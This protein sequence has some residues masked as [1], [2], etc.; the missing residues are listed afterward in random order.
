MN[1][2]D[3]LAGFLVE[4]EE[5]LRDMEGALLDCDG[6]ATSAEV[7]NR[8]FRCAHTIKGSAGLF[9]LQDIVEFVHVLET[10]L[11]HVR[12]GKVPLHETLISLLLESRDH[13]RALVAA[14]GTP[15]SPDS[16]LSDQSARLI[17]ALHAASAIGEPPPFE[18]EMHPQRVKVL[19]S[20][21]ER[22]I[23]NPT[24][25]AWNLLVRFAPGVLASGMDPL[26]VIGYLGTFCE[27]CK[28]TI[29]DEALPVP[30]AFQPQECYL[31]FK[32]DLRTAADRSRIESA[33]DF[34]RD[35]C[36]LELTEAATDAHSSSVLRE[37]PPAPDQPAPAPP[38]TTLAPSA[39]PARGN[40]Q[41][42]QTRSSS[43]DTHSSVRVDA[44][45]LDAL[46]TRVG[47]L[48]IETAA[49]DMVARR[50][51]NCE[52]QERS[53]RLSALV[54]EVRENALQLRMIKIGGVFERFRRIVRD[55]SRGLGKDI[56]LIVRGQDTELDKT[57][58]EKLADPLTHLVRNAVDHGIEPPEVRKARGKPERGTV[59]LNAYH[60]S[61]SVVIEV[62]DDGGGL[63]A[64]RILAKA[65][66]RGLIKADA[67][68][69][70]TDI[71]NL[72]FEPG[73]STAEAVT[74]LS[75]R[76]VGM[77]VVKKNITALRGTINLASNHGRGTTVA[78]RLPLTLAI[79]NGF[80]VLVGVSTYVIPL[81]AIAECI[82]YNSAENREFLDLRGQ[83]VP[84][85]RLRD[86]FA[87]HGNA[88]RRQSVVVVRNGATPVGLVVDSLIGE[89][90][91]VIKPL[92]SLFQSLECL[93]GSSIL[94][95]GEVALILDVAALVQQASAR[96]TSQRYSRTGA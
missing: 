46:I 29:L 56:N 15:P 34:V 36:T 80:Q 63:H 18:P 2:D 24:E 48:M 32:L 26:G 39:A 13:T 89:L 84:L 1:M 95:N 50:A 62:Q 60:D 74:T 88:P 94:G 17:R 37:P 16:P 42:F 57:L 33:F 91:T 30:E 72:V 6:D 52:L 4:S 67:A 3:A 7:I 38:R 86:L 90:Q 22:A 92:G 20:Q 8:I 40:A 71:F 47:E 68:L 81:D 27:L 23:G 55:V 11:D 5:L 41:E 64:E 49:I 79:I 54:G 58:V 75:G 65:R 19:T 28:V 59:T 31:G 43:R 93:A 70:E 82:E 96:A 69:P 76:G 45:K 51:N 25:T 10:I 66:E 44:A 9:G 77:D 61:G 21:A 53:S 87:A 85:V 83:I 35:E 73:F 78:M 14:I 12:H